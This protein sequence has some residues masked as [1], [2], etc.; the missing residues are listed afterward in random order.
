MRKIANTGKIYA[1]CVEDKVVRVI[2]FRFE[3]EQL[4]FEFEKKKLQIKAMELIFIVKSQN[5]QQ[6]NQ[7][8]RGKK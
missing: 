5:N 1:R 6:K 3:Q 8:L 4:V 2:K 7:L